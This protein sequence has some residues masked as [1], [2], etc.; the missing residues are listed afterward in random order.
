MDWIQLIAEIILP[1]VATIVSVYLIP[2]LKK[3]KINDFAYDLVSAAE[4]LFAEGENK[5][6]LDFTIKELCKK[7]SIKE[8][9]ARIIIEASVYE[10][11]KLKKQL[12][13]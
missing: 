2:I 10:V 7:F 13:L 5:E 11:K 3:K 12:I 1:L 8:P 4:Q 9:D 6:K